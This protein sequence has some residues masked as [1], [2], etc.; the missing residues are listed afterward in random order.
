M[1]ISK[2]TIRIENKQNILPS[3]I[4]AIGLGLDGLVII[5]YNIANKI[6]YIQY[7]PDRKLQTYVFFELLNNSPLWS[8]SYDIIPHVGWNASIFYFD[9]KFILKID[10]T[11]IN[12]Y[13]DTSLGLNYIISEM[14]FSAPNF[15][16]TDFTNKSLIP[17]FEPIKPPKDFKMKLYDYQQR[18]LAKMLQM[19]N[20]QTNF[21]FNYT[22]NINFKGVDILFDPVSNCRVN[23]D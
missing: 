2:G 3:D 22:Y 19:E 11:L 5:K 1:D 23:K 8:I 20:N 17:Y 21:T 13:I 18:T 12:N 6:H 10:T 15:T 14:Y 9:I 4:K 16:D 7:L